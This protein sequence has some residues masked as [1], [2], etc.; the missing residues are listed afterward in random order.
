[1]GKIIQTT[2]F[3]N[4]SLCTLRWFLKWD[5]LHPQ[6]LS[7]YLSSLLNSQF[8]RVGQVHT[9]S[10]ISLNHIHIFTF[11]KTT[12]HINSHSPGIQNWKNSSLQQLIHCIYTSLLWSTSFSHTFSHITI[13]LSKPVICWMSH[14]TILTQKS[15]VYMLFQWLFHITYLSNI[16]THYQLEFR[17][18][19]VD[20][21]SL[22]LLLFLPI[23]TKEN[24]CFLYI[25]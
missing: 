22:L 9:T 12:A 1:M 19:W 20:C 15:L 14:I 25:H 2:R 16:F 7:T 5:L 13:D 21:P 11:I 10:T 3:V 4:Y 8:N 24:F 6:F 17:K 18:C 23:R